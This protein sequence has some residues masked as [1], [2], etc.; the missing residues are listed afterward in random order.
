MGPYLSADVA[1]SPFFFPFFFFSTQTHRSLK[2]KKTEQPTQEKKEKKVNSGQKL[3]LVLF[4][5]SLCVFNYN[6]A[7]EL[8]KLKT[9][10][11]CFQF[12]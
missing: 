8:W 10:K 9:T 12:P 3:R 6:I 1:F 5:G 4:V 7:I 2:K 11:I